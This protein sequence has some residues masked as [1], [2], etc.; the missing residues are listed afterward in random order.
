MRSQKTIPVLLLI[1]SVLLST[2]ISSAK[3]TA[4]KSSK[5][6][7]VE[8]YITTADRSML[9][10]KISLKLKTKQDS[11]A[12]IQLHPDE[13]FQQIDGFGVAITGSTGEEY[14]QSFH[15]G[16]AVGSEDPREITVYLRELLRSRGLAKHLRENGR[17]TAR[18]FGWKTMLKDLLRKIE[19]IAWTRGVDLD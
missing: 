13:S 17:E 5:K 19:F 11:K 12:R 10:E 14:I 6:Q 2:G 15:N 3:E 8:A 9:F 7:K 18:L 4:C 16:I 1:I